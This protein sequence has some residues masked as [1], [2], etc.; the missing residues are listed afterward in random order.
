MRSSSLSTE[1]AV[2][3]IS[4]LQTG[5]WLATNVVFALVL[6]VVLD[7]DLPRRGLIRVSARSAGLEDAR[8]RLRATRR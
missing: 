2:S 8:V 7:F 5:V 6:F 4:P 3:G 1:P